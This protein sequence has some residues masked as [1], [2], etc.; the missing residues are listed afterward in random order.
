MCRRVAN[1]EG[2]RSTTNRIGTA[3]TETGFC[4]RHTTRFFKGTRWKCI[5]VI[6]GYC[7]D[8]WSGHMS[9][10]RNCGGCRR[11]LWCGRARLDILRFLVLV[12]SLPLRD[13]QHVHAEVKHT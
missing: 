11:G 7:K 5:E 1:R 6:G 4:G 9:V 8:G 3:E 12:C 13:R 10:D 2:S